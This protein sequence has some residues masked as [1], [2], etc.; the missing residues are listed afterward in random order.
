MRPILLLCFSNSLYFAAKNAHLE[1]FYFQDRIKNIDVYYS[2]QC[3]STSAL[4]KSV[5]DHSREIN[6]FCVYTFHQT[7]GRGQGNN[8][9]ESEPGKNLAVTF[10]FPALASD[11]VSQ[12]KAIALGVREAID[13]LCDEQITI[14]W[15]N[16]IYAGNKKICG[17]LLETWTGPDEQKIFSAGI[18]I[19]VNQVFTSS[20]FP[21]ISL[22]QLSGKG[23]DMFNVLRQVIISI[24]TYIIS[25]KNNE[26]VV[27]SEFNK[28]LYMKDDRVSLEK[29]S[30]IIATGRL[31]SVDN[32]GRIVI[33]NDN[34]QLVRFHHGD[35]R[36]KK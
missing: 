14:K 7:A 23:F 22:F 2:S 35:T 11:P 19:N 12:N 13:T 21:A 9:W 28:W 30:E 31:D 16:D 6:P 27:E 26:T 5:I 4:A 32:A 1:D 29:N 20:D 17:L 36:L 3:K 24:H 15:P 25:L 18:G 33:E 34:H 10:I 8:Q